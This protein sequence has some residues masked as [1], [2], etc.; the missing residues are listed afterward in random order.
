MLTDDSAA[1]NRVAHRRIEL[2]AVGEDVDLVVEMDR[3]LA[4]RLDDVQ[5]VVAVGPERLRDVVVDARREEQH[6][7]RTTR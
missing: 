5:E 4:G 6:Q 2:R 7:R 3:R 1:Q